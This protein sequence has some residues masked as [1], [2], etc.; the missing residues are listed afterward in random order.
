MTAL[1]KHFTLTELS[2]SATATR[3]GLN[4]T[5][6]A[7]KVANLTRLCNELLE[8]IRE[9]AGKPVTVTSGYRSPAVNA[10]V[11]GA[12]K[13]AHLSGFAADINCF[14]Y[15]TSR[16]F[17]TLLVKELRARN[18]KFDQLILEFDTW[19]HVGLIGPGGKQRGQV[20]TAKRMASG[21]TEYFNGI[22]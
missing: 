5:P 20:L 13:S 17:A 15:G 7:D 10:A 6:P 22:A 12:I 18:I 19:V 16:Q 1:S 14:S 3:K 8:P 2:I 4:N 9:I 11:G 21:K